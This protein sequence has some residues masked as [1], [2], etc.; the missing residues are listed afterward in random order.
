M[1][2][3]KLVG[4]YLGII[5]AM[6]LLQLW[7][8][9]GII[10]MFLMVAMGS[11]AI[12]VLGAVFNLMLVHVG[13]Q[14]A[15]GRI[16]RAWLIL[17]VAMYAGFGLYGGYG[18][19]AAD[20]MRRDL[21]AAAYFHGPTPKAVVFVDNIE[22]APEAAYA[23]QEFRR[24]TKDVAVYGPY[25][26]KP[27]PPGAI[28]VKVTAPRPLPFSDSERLQADPTGLVRAQSVVPAWRKFE[29]V[30]DVYDGD[31]L[32]GHGESGLVEHPLPLPVP[33][34]GCWINDLG[35]GCDAGLLPLFMHYGK[36]RQYAPDDREAWLA[37]LMGVKL[38]AP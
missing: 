11:A 8:Y 20:T 12:Y 33:Y 28:R 36:L 14:A 18:W 26:E 25:D 7:T 21:E 5:A 17:P 13:V 30:Y 31:K 38:R 32:I 4:I 19:M 22:G 1:H 15:R 2:G 23:A 10:I 24:V 29:F 9:T 37:H 16:E 6:I 3:L 35:G 27:V 34:F